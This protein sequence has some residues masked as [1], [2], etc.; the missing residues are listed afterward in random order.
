MYSIT[1]FGKSDSFIT[2]TCDPQWIEMTENL[3]SFETPSDC[4]DLI[5]LVFHEKL[6]SMLDELTKKSILG[7]VV[8]YN[9]VAE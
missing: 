5:S 7:K 4:S 2:F 9:Y 8:R 1:K 6:S 3:K